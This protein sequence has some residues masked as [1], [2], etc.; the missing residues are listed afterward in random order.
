MRRRRRA[1]AAHRARRGPSHGASGVG[2]LALPQRHAADGGRA[3]PVQRPCGA[4]TGRP[5]AARGTRLLPPAPTARCAAAGST[6]SGP[7]AHAS[8]RCRGSRAHQAGPRC[9]AGAPA[10]G[11]WAAALASERRRLGMSCP[12][13][14]ERSEAAGLGFQTAAHPFIRHQISSWPPDLDERSKSFRVR[15]SADWAELGQCAQMGRA[16]GERFTG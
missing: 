1:H 3:L 12:W 11:P 9:R 14:K 15:I 8:T 13:R 5:V 7:V 16:Q 6:R 2:L 4:W 10:A